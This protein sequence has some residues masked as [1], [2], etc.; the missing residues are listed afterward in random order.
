VLKHMKNR[1]VLSGLLFILVGAFVAIK[2]YNDYPVGTLAR[3]GPG[4]FPLILG[5]ALALVGVV[6]IALALNVQ[7][8]DLKPNFGARTF[9]AV[10]LSALV[11]GLLVERVGLMPSAL[12]LTLIAAAAEKRFVLSR[13]LFL[14]FSLGLLTW[15]IFV[16]GLEMNLSAFAW[17]F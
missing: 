16:F 7:G 11:F 15:L 1:D 13:S 8:L 14:G 9:V 5:V 3:M 6:V 10:L 17:N 4:Y 12:A 2:A